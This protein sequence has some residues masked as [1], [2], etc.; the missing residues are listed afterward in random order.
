MNSY[1]VWIGSEQANCSMY[2]VFRAPTDEDAQRYATAQ[3]DEH[4]A[5]MA[6]GGGKAVDDSTVFDFIRLGS[7]ERENEDF[8]GGASADW[9]VKEEG[10]ARLTW[11]QARGEHTAQQIGMDSWGNG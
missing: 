1:V 3:T 7:Q 4:D 2:A 5:E 8:S 6:R 11:S 10:A 9:E